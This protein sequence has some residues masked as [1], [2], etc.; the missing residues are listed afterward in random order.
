MKVIKMPNIKPI[1]CS[2]CGC[3]YEYEQG[4]ELVKVNKRNYWGDIP[5]AF[6]YFLK[7]PVCGRTN[8]LRFDE[9]K[10]EEAER[11]EV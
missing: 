2:D 6:L 5:N 3:E 9:E 7:C 10:V 11:Y 4:D 1:K 8:E